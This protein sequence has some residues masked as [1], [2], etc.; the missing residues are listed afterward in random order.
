[1]GAPKDIARAP[2][3]NF[4]VESAAFRVRIERENS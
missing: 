1:M 2:L 3:R 4:L